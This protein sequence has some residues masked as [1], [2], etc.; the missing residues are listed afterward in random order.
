MPN[1]NY[2]AVFSISPLKNNVKKLF[3]AVFKIT[4]QS[5]AAQVGKL[6]HAC[7]LAVY[8]KRRFHKMC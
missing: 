5:I 8:K 6:H 4:A 2:S 1:S 3:L 7:E